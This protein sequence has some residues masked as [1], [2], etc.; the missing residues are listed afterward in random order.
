MDEIT[1][2]VAGAFGRMGQEVVRMVKGE[3]SFRLV[4]LIDPKGKEG[5]E[6]PVYTGVVDALIEKRPDVLIDFT[7]PSSVFEN[8]R[9]ALEMGVR[10]VV[11]TT[12]LKPDEINTLSRLAGEGKVGAVIAPNF[13]L[14][15][16]L[17]MRFAQMAAKYM[18]NVEILEFHH[19][20]K[21]DAPSG[22]ALKTAEMIQEVREERKQ[23]NPLEEERLQGAR[24]GYID[25]FRI[26]SIR[27]PGY[28]AHQ[29][30]IFGKEGEILTI[31]HDSLS[32]TSFME[33]VKI[34]VKKVIQLEELVYG[35]DRLLD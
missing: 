2:A 32:R 17:M 29:E 30:V 34:A 5:G 25:G 9:A 6:D 7:T 18:P 20:Q 10:P 15:A 16:V 21:L 4:A 28:V 27:L 13:A 24:G 26:H 33:G 8:A 3:A 31:R 23:G 1:I 22:T 12:G 14:G 35:L 11:G 19:D